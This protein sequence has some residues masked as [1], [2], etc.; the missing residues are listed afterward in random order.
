MRVCV[1]VWMRVCGCVCACLMCVHAWLGSLHGGCATIIAVLRSSHCAYI[2]LPRVRVLTGAVTVQ[3]SPR[4]LAR[5]QQANE[6]TTVTV[7]ALPATSPDGSGCV[8]SPGSVTTFTTQLS[9]VG[10]LTFQV[11]MRSSEASLSSPMTVLVP[12]TS[13]AF[14][15]GVTLA[16]PTLGSA[17]ATATATP[18]ALWSTPPTVTALVECPAALDHQPGLTH[19]LATADVVTHP[20]LLCGG[21]LSVVSSDRLLAVE[22]ASATLGFDPASAALYVAVRVTG[23][24]D[25]VCVDGGSCLQY[26][27][28]AF[29]G[30]VHDIDT[31]VHLCTEFVCVGNRSGA[32]VCPFIL[33]RC[34]LCVHAI[35][36]RVPQGGAGGERSGRL[37]RHPVP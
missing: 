29:D 7:C 26:H 19:C 28:W 21:A 16:S 5:L 11:T 18:L 15:L 35:A 6:T 33:V 17:S 24:H 37:T 31:Y 23:A 3:S 30:V 22:A 9:S 36:C 2:L 20:P 4:C 32:A 12:A 10:D 1:C 25:A 34:L 8:G 27:G 14:I 13:A